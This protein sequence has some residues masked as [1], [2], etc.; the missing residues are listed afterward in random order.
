MHVAGALKWPEF[1]HTRTRRPEKIEQYVAA[2]RHNNRVYREHL[3]EVAGL[4]F[5]VER[6]WAKNVYWMNGIV[7]DEKTFGANRSKLEAALREHS[8][9][10]RPFFHPMHLQPAL[11]KYGCDCSGSYP[12]SLDL[13]RNGLYLPSGSALTEV[14]I[15]NICDIVKSAAG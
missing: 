10:Y 14:Q 4:R 8:I 2:R 6:E 1:T 15:E 13:G 12:V 3:R 11:K 9:G 7:V 5:Q